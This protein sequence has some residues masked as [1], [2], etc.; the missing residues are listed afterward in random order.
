MP[1]DS[2]NH[3]RGVRVVSFESRR[4][5]E[6]ERLIRNYGG[7]PLVAPSM[8]EVPLERNEQALAFAADLF[9]GHFDMMLFLTGVGTRA[10]GKVVETRYEFSKFLD[11]LRRLQIIARGPKPVAVLREWDLPIH[12]RVPE[13]NTWREILAELE[14]LPAGKRIAV[15]EYGKSNTELLEA[16]RAGGLEV[17]TVPVYQWDLPEDTA[18]LRKAIQ[19]ICESRAAVVLFTTSVQIDHLFR[20]AAEMGC[21]D[22]L[23]ARLNQMMIAS[24][25]PMASEA[26]REHS[27]HVDFEPTHPKMGFLVKEAAEQSAAILA[28][29]N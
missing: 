3:F 6:M 16:L 24:I 23:R 15:Q 4:A 2:S 18:P 12:I 29:K 26:L 8:R 22:Q 20:V 14:P 21:E 27:L 9:E 25:G 7:D 10:L 13:P 1:I 11:A 17:T 19:T 5:I 28:A